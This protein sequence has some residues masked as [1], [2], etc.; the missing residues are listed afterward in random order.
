MNPILVGY[1]FV[2][3]VLAI[4]SYGFVDLNLRLSTNS[5]YQALQ[6]PLSDLVYKMRPTASFVFVLILIALFASYLVF[7]IRT[8][9]FFPSFRKLTRFIPIITLI[10]A[11]SFPALTYDL[12][13]YIMTAKVSFTYHENPYIVMPVEIPNDPNLAFTRAANKLALY[14][15]VWLLLTAIPNTLGGG[16]VWRTIVVYKIMNGMAYLLMTYMIYRFTKSVRN[17]V[18]FA[19]NPLVIIE[20]LVSGHND[21]YMML[22]ALGGLLLWKNSKR[23]A[24]FFLLLASGLI[25]GAT[26]ILAPLLYFTKYPFEKILVYSYWLMAVVFFVVAPV[27]E[28]LY[29]WYA[30]WLISIASFL[31]PKRY[32]RIW[33]FTIVLSFA[34]ELR[35]LPYIYM[36]YY[37]GPGPMLRML[38]TVIPVGLYVLWL[39]IIKKTPLWHKKNS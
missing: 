15:P 37:G 27:R 23:F 11:A 19:L 18:F 26:L 29:P 8:D 12:F 2:I 1:P 17:A 31:S 7:L 16:D 30:V 28:E 35:N 3:L 34:L 21:I 39:F 25:K 6:T 13:N 22:L 20:T 32:A 14:G 38:V 24:G 33:E 9:D 5:W 36:G 10:L 4:F